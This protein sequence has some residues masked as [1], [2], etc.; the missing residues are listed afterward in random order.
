M[1]VTMT[2]SRPKG[3][4]KTETNKDEC[5]LLSGDSQ[6]EPCAWFN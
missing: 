1:V 4:N 2:E 5:A 6:F 3:D